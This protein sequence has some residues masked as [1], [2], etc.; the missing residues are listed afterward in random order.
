MSLIND[1]LKRAQR[2]Q[3]Q[4]SASPPPELQFRPVE[5]EQ[6]ARRGPGLMLPL[7]V[8]FALFVGVVVV[9]QVVHKSGATKPAEAKLQTQAVADARPVAP[10]E[11]AA[12]PASSE[13]S[14]SQ[15]P[16]DPVA[17]APSAPASTAT[18]TPAP[19]SAAAPVSAAP[20]N[21]TTNVPAATEAPA[22]KPAPL[23]LQ[24]I[25]YNPTRPSAMI[26]GRTLFVGDKL[27]ELRVVAIDQESATLAGAGQT[28]VLTLPQ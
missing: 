14:P 27:G 16:A 10:A 24:A 5:P 15:K 19:A 20:A 4:A 9:W 12:R 6:P 23:K 21:A 13:A 28:Q 3:Q 22:P 1:A 11:P 7:G 17:T 25:V 26:G 18:P 8:V 2:T